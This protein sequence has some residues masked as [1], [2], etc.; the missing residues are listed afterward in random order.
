MAMELGA[1]RVTCFKAC[2][3]DGEH[4]PSIHRRDALQEKPSRKLT[5]EEIEALFDELASL[6][7]DG[8]ALS[9][10]QIAMRVAG[11]GR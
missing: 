9:D 5:D 2:D 1:K 8:H 11:I 4:E 3:G 7:S 10:L 6:V